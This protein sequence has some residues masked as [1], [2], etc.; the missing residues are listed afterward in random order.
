[1]DELA[2]VLGVSV[3]TAWNL[4]RSGVVPHVRVGRRVLVA[5]S[6]V[7]RF[8]ADGGVRKASVAA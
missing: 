2:W 6:E 1:V 4:V 5:R 3:D 7:E 8:L